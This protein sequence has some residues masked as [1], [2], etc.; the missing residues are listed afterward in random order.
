[1]PSR[2]TASFTCTHV[3]AIVLTNST[4]NSVSQVNDSR[5]PHDGVYKLKREEALTPEEPYLLYCARKKT[6]DSLKLEIR[7]YEQDLGLD[8]RVQHMPSFHH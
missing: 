3:V 4:T 6:D 7:A 1:M 8:D 5:F 2:N